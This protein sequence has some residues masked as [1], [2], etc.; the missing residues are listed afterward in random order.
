MEELYVYKKVTGFKASENTFVDAVQAEKH[1][2]AA[3]HDQFL[4]NE[5]NL[6]LHLSAKT[7]LSGDTLCPGHISQGI[8][9][10]QREQYKK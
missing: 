7:H 9:R 1:G 2:L 10:V 5:H 6:T 3:S 4:P 8:F